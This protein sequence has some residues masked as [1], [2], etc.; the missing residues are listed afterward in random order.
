MKV[1]KEGQLSIAQTK[2]YDAV[3]KAALQDKFLQDGPLDYPNRNII[4]TDDG[5][6]AGYY[7]PHRSS[8]K[9]K[10]AWRPGALFIAPA[11][12]GQ[13]LMFQA[14]SE[15]Y[16]KPPRRG[17]AWIDDRNSASIALFTKLGFLKDKPYEDEG[18]PGHWWILDK[19]SQPGY[20]HWK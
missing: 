7:T 6:V 15:F 11:F 13:N 2:Q 9:G 17:V 5:D 18:Y 16:Q 1:L 19:V 20:T 12:R 10:P 4:V 3:K 8:L 14:L